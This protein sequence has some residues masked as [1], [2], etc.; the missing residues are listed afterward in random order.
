MV[1]DETLAPLMFHLGDI[2]TV[3]G[4]TGGQ[5]LVSL[6]QNFRNLHFGPPMDAIQVARVAVSNAV[7]FWLPDVFHG[8]YKA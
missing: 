2:T 1:P 3:T 8:P 6:S 5:T 4:I 7:M